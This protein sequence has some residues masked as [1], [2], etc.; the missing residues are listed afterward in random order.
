M[1]VLVVGDVVAAGAKGTILCLM[2]ADQPPFGHRL[3][4]CIGY[5][6]SRRKPH[7]SHHVVSAGGTF[8]KS[9]Q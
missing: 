4:Q 7:T 9:R 1:L 2:H 5:P 8:T 3:Q 6:G